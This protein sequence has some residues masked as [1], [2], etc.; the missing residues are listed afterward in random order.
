MYSHSESKPDLFRISAF[1]EAVA[2]F[3]YFSVIASMRIALCSVDKSC[4]L[5][6]P[7]ITEVKNITDLKMTSV[8]RSEPVQSYVPSNLLTTNFKPSFL[9]D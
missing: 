4:F 3:C 7:T 1:L 9:R 5:S 6:A 8:C 2:C